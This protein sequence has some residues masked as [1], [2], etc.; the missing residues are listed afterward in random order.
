MATILFSGAE[1]FEQIVNITSTEGPMRNILNIGQANSE[2]KT[3]KDYIIYTY[4]AQRQEQITPRGQNF[5][6][7]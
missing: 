2:K 5:Y 4:I 6:C 3:F 1:P 7:N